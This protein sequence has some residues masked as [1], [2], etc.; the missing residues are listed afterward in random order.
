[1]KYGELE[2]LNLA[3]RSPLSSDFV[4]PSRRRYR[5]PFILIIINIVTERC[6]LEKVL[7]YVHGRSHLAKYQDP[8]S[9]FLQ[10]GQYSVQKFEFSGRPPQIVIHCPFIILIEN[11]GV[12]A[13]LTELHE[14]IHQTF[15]ANFST[16]KDECWMM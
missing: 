12:I 6:V 2:A 14:S 4:D 15:L 11:V 1:M 7:H 3:N 9:C 13:K 10:F 8:V 5:K 16:N